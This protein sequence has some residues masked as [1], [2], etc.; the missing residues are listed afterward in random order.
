MMFLFVLFVFDTPSDILINTGFTSL[1]RYF[2]L[3]EELEILK[4]V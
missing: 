4:D 1:L 2:P 3:N